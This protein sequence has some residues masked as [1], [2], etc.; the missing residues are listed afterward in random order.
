MDGKTYYYQILYTAWVLYEYISGRQQAWYNL[1]NQPWLIATMYN[2]G[3]SEPHAHTDIWWSF[4]TI[5]WEKYSFW[6]LAML[7]Y[8]YLE[9]YG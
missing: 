1:K 6:W 7:I 3:Y 9:I 8:Y 4:M 2:I 5:E